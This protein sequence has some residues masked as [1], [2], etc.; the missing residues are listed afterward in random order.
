MEKLLKEL[1]ELV[2]DTYSKYGEE[3][4]MVSRNTHNKAFSGI[5]IANEIKNETEI[6]NKI[7]FMLIELTIDLVKRDRINT[8]GK[9]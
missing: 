9:L 1:K 5:E 4:I 6:G 7:L 2:I 8:N 3:K